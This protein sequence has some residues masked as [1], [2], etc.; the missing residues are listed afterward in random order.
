MTRISN[1]PLYPSNNRE[2]QGGIRMGYM[3]FLTYISEEVAKVGNSIPTNLLHPI[4]LSKLSSPEW[5][6]YVEGPLRQSQARDSL[7]LG[8]MRPAPHPASIG[9]ETSLLGP[10]ELAEVDLA[11]IMNRRYNR[12]RNE[13]DFDEEHEERETS[14]EP[15]LLFS[16]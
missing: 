10:S 13:D 14:E 4:V 15:V 6:T 3:G 9:L 8:G 1:I 5:I 7:V 12:R 2:K 11:A 16:I